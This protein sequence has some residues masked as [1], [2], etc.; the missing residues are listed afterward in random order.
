MATFALVAGGG[1]NAW[2]W[3]R[4]VPA[5]EERGHEVVAVP[6]PTGEPGLGL[7]D[8]ASAVVE[9]VN[10]A[11]L[12][13]SGDVILV[14]HSLAGRYLPLA[15]GQIPGSRMVF[16]CALI[17]EEAAEGEAPPA[18]TEGERPAGVGRG[19]IDEQGRLYFSDEDAAAL[20]YSDCDQETAAWAVSHLAPQG[21]WVIREPFPH[22]GWP[23]GVRSAYILCK[24]DLIVP[25]ERAQEMAARA[26]VEPIELPGGHSPFLSQPAALVDTLEHLA[27]FDESWGVKR[28]R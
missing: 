22:G 7:A 26:G 20:F 6:L 1:H 5:L 2:C 16:L 8:F 13:A 18:P 24:D 21:T 10:G 25:P 11:N 28:P 14:G 12:A 3:E 4:V 15:A 23:V 9:G 17:A 27:E 19:Q